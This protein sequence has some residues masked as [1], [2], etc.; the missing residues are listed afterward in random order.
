MPTIGPYQLLHALGTCQVGDVWSA[1]DAGN[2]PVTIAVLKP[3][4]ASDKALRDA[5]AGAAN[6]LAQS[7]Q[8]PI[9]AGDFSSPTP[10]IAA[11]A[12]DGS[13]VAQVFTA[14]GMTYQPLHAPG[15]DATQVV[16][17]PPSSSA[18]PAHSAES[19]TSPASAGER[20]PPVP[21]F[22]QQPQ[23]GPVP[24]AAGPSP[25]SAPPGSASPPPGPVSAPP[26]PLPMPGWAPP[27]SDM[28]PDDLVPIAVTPEDRPRSRTRLLIGLLVLG[29]L[30]LGGT[31]GA[32]A[33]LTRPD[34]DVPVT[35]STSISIPAVPPSPPAPDQPGIEPPVSDEWPNDFARFAPDEPT[36]KIADLPG[37]PFDFF[38]PEGWN[39]TDN[40][41][42][43]GVVRYTCGPGGRSDEIGGDIIVRECPEPC[44]SDQRIAMRGAV[45]AW[46]LQWH[47]DSGYRSWAATEELDGE[48][49]FGVVM[50]GYARST[51]EGRMDRQVVLRMTAPLGDQE[52][53]QKVASS[54]RGAIRN[55]LTEV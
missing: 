34:P 22:E 18:P 9:I 23:P 35:P 36:E 46:G 42:G 49:R 12:S 55:S 21:G 8:I 38:V 28:S 1:V 52:A 16:T 24:P 25:V 3:E 32:I 10:W 31:G 5:F 30:V 54:V 53:I 29:I 7:R 43:D 14:L 45:E 37:V 15:S 2:N 4:T 47:R 19:P 20:P 13:V 33:F 50:V 40:S 41:A 44:A 26:Q 27:V 6:G 48:P 39:C 17:M 51:F 11:S